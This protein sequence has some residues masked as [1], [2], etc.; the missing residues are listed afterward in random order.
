M[1]LPESPEI[2]DVLNSF[3]L[4]HIVLHPRTAEQQYSGKPDREAFAIFA[5][6]SVNKVIYNGDVS[7]VEH[8]EYKDVMIGRG[9]LADPL[10]GRKIQG[11][12]PPEALLWDFHEAFRQNC[13]ELEQPLQKLKTFWE[14][15]LPDVPKNLRK[16]ILKSRTLDEYSDLAVC[17]LSAFRKPPSVAAFSSP[18]RHART[19]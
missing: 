9:L 1:R 10:L 7:S 3:S 14:Y 5:G 13:M 11:E 6:R 8:L 2:L 4:R 16:K 17:Q 18:F 12:T 19:P 15:F